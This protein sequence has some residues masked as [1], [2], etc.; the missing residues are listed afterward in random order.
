MGGYVTPAGARRD[1]LTR[2]QWIDHLQ[3]LA[4]AEQRACPVPELKLEPTTPDYL[5]EVRRVVR[6]LS[7]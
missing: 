1:A 7:E 5:M 2:G 6:L 3:R 4:Q